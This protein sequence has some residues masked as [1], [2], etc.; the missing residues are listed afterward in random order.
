M[1]HWRTMVQSEHFCAADLWDD[2]RGEYVKAVLKITKVA[3]GTVTG[4]KG[5]KK[6][7]PFLTLEDVN[8]RKMRA[9][10]GANPTN[11]TA[12][13]TALGTPDAKKWVG[14]W[15][16]LYVTKVDSPEGQVDAIR[17]APKRLDPP[18]QS[19]GPK[20]QPPPSAPP[21]A[22]ETQ[23]SSSPPDAEELELIAARDREDAR[24]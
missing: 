5:R 24:Q 2:A 8:G 16:G 19:S 6:G 11:C 21:K 15:I 13:S 10:F 18:G 12:I 1:A 20:S 9:E 17:V 4:Q 14:Q 22:T 7:L 3:Q 23:A